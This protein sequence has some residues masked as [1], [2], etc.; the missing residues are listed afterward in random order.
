MTFRPCLVDREQGSALIVALLIALLLGA[1]GASLVTLTTTEILL[2]ASFRQSQEA[3][4]GADAALELALHE[5]SLVPDWSLVLA[6]PPANLTSAFVDGTMQ[7]VGPDGKVI[8][9]IGLTAGRQRD[10]DARDGPGA[11]SPQWRLYAHAPLGDALGAPRLVPPLHIVVWV[12]DDREDADGDP[13]VDRN[14]TIVVHAEAFGS[15]GSRR[16]VEAAIARPPLRL[17]SWRRW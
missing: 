4:Y 8:D 7:P 5:L 15:G 11:D 17:V 9:L 6:A 10:G 3:A 2:S 12:A 14:G 16:A 1:V 13:T